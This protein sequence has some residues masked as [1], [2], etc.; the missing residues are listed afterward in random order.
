M[1]PGMAA[2]C[3]DLLRLC[4]VELRQSVAGL[5]MHTQKLVEFCMIRLRVAMLRALDRSVA[6]V[7][8]SATAWELFG[9]P[10]R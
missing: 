10:M 4:L 8:R 3:F 1:L 6:S 5:F 9:L 2:E 7:C